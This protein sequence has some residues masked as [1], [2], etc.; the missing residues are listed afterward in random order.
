MDKDQALNATDLVAQG[1]QMRTDEAMKT[2]EMMDLST[3][4]ICS[5]AGVAKSFRM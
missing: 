2:E 5:I 3:T 4:V 1:Q